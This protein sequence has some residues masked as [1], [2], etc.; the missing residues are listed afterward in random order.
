MNRK[1]ND[2]K[3]VN[4]ENCV[5]IILNTH[6][7]APDNQ[8]DIITL[9]NLIREA[10]NRLQNS[11]EKKDAEAIMESLNK[12]ESSIDVSH[13]QESLVLFVNAEKNI[14]EYI[15]LPIPVTD[16][17]VI[18]DTFAT[19]DLLRAVHLNAG[20]YILVLSQQN[21]RFLQAMNDALVKEFTD[22]FPL[23]NKGF[24]TNPGIESSYAARQTNLM[25]EFFNLV[26]KEVNKIRKENPLP[27]LICTEEANYYE[28][29]KV[30]DE[31]DSIY[32]MYLNGN[33]LDEKA[34][35]IVKEA[36]PLIKDEIE[37]QN[38]ERKKNLDRAVGN[39]LFLSD[40]NE[41]AGAIKEGRVAT[42]YVQEGLFQP[43]VF[44]GDHIRLLAENEE[45]PAGFI[46]DI[47]DEL[48]ELNMEYNGNTV[49]L[50]EGN[51]D[52]FNGFAAVTRY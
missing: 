18:G 46:D 20:Y 35:A 25:A 33:R 28:Y 36:W 39:G 21:V 49:F 27:V 15:R 52:K 44:E 16:R 45:K 19:R 17:V 50:P 48:I 38:M 5:T 47:F 37:R 43:A 41:I 6:R 51:L 4:A 32:P 10:G 29:L 8:K 12:L 9:K 40:V 7:T 3:K 23:E 26:D 1:L 13:N 11:A 42:L 2:L 34:A 31:K 14:A 30:A 24:F 22:T